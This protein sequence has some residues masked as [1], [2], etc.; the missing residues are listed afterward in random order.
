MPR[1]S[2]CPHS[3]KHFLVFK[4]FILEFKNSSSKKGLWTLSI[5]KDAN[6]KLPGVFVPKKRG[7]HAREKGGFQHQ[8]FVT[9]WHDLGWCHIEVV[10]VGQEEVQS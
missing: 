9:T 10:G 4:G 6:R 1:P 7:K 2:L 3:E 5:Q 8:L